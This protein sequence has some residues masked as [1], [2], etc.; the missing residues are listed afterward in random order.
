MQRNCKKNHIQEIAVQIDKILYYP[1]NQS[2][3]ETN[4]FEVLQ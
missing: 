2:L 4:G 1:I 3:L